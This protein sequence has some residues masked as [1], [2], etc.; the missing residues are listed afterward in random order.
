ME[1][2]DMTRTENPLHWMGSL[3]DQQQLEQT[4]FIKAATL[5]SAYKGGDWRYIGCEQNIVFMAPKAETNYVVIDSQGNE[6]GLS[7]EAFGLL[8]TIQA[9]GGLRFDP[10]Y[11]FLDYRI[12]KLK[13]V[14]ESVGAGAIVAFLD[15]EHVCR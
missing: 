3:A 9:M 2:F 15:E 4:I 8:S 13:E 14:A 10:K 7:S 6:V 1:F 5:S 12:R 11:K